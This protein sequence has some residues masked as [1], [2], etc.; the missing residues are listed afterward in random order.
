MPGVSMDEDVVVMWL[1]ANK[2]RAGLVSYLVSTIPLG[3]GSIGRRFAA[4]LELSRLDRRCKAPAFGEHHFHCKQS[5]PPLLIEA[6]HKHKVQNFDL[7]SL[8]VSLTV[9]GLTL[10]AQL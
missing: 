4:W 6:C 3:N 8:S 9:S 7:L 1:R 2:L 10:S 5:Q